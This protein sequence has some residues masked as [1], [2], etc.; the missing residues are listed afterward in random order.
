MKKR[1]LTPLEYSLLTIPIL[2]IL[3]L[4]SRGGWFQQILFYANPLG[5]ARAD[6]Q[7][8]NCASRLKVIGLAMQQYMGDYNDRLP[9]FVIGGTT[10]TSFAI[11]STRV[12]WTDAVMPYVYG[13]PV[14]RCPSDNTPQ[15]WPNP[16][17]SGCTSYWFNRNLSALTRHK[18][19]RTEAV[20]LLGEGGAP[21]ATN[22]TYNKSSL[23]PA[24]INDWNSP[25][26]RHLGGANYLFVDG[27]VKWLQPQEIST[28]AQGMYTFNP[29][30]IAATTEQH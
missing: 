30:R 7:R 25:A 17:K 24:W 11:G 15:G 26:Q 22:A 3:A 20:I 18:I 28:G 21:D 19:T 6:T 8:H 14:P 5:R 13:D 2:L 10:V 29:A 23:S 16:L 27:H 4:T 1:K 9:P 12:G